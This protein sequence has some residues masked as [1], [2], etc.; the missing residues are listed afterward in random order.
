MA[1]PIEPFDESKLPAEAGAGGGDENVAPFDKSKY[2]PMDPAGIWMKF[3]GP[4]ATV[5]DVKMFIQ[6]LE[7]MLQTL[8]QQN[9]AA[10]K[11]ALD[12]QK[13]AQEENG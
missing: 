6:G 12:A 10:F 13:R 9:D 1:T 7:K 3:L 5:D 4:Q 2:N 11:R 8:V